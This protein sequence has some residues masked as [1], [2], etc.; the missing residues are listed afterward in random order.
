MS[1][2]AQLPRTFTVNADGKYTLTVASIGIALTV[3]RLRRERHELVGE[4]AVRCDLPGA[5]AVDGVLSVADFNLSSANARRDRARLLT[6]R[7][8]A[9]DLPWATW[10]EEL[11]QRVLVAER[12]GAPAVD[13]RAVDVP[14]AEDDWRLAGFALPRRHPA[15]VF[16]DGGSLKSYLGLYLAGQLARAGLRVGLFDWELAAEDHRRRLAQLFGGEM[17]AITYARC[18]RA[19]VHE[20]DRLRRI[21]HEHG[22]AYAVFDSVAFACDG[23][24]EAAESATTYFRAV[25]QIGVGSLHIAHMSKAEDGDK[26]PFGSAFWFN[27][28]RAVWFVKRAETAA[29]DTA[30]VDLGVFHRKANLTAMRP[31]FALRATFTD[32]R[33]TF[34]L[35][36]AASVDDFAQ[37]LPLWQ[38]VRGT[39]RGG[40]LTLAAIADELEAQVGSVEK[41]VRRG[42]GKVFTRVTGSD[43]VTRWGLLDR[44][45]R[46]AA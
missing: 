31:A 32:E 14:A 39:L 44:A 22:L 1:L 7:S 21:A 28:A 18:E 35:T 43:G 34:T 12:A 27:G 23:P 38:R 4:L 5:Q 8:R 3:D 36:D 20:A 46:G 2:E 26:R 9:E 40:P 13:L 45:F 17:P 15:I 6:Q 24:P 10:L 33:V 19:L 11:A 16:G 37:R 42:E 30:D 29:A 41:A 25:R